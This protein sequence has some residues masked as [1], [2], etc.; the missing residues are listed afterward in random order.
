[1]DNDCIEVH[2][3]MVDRAIDKLKGELY[4]QDEAVIMPL[5]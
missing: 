4:D 1:M 2:R 5:T 3:L